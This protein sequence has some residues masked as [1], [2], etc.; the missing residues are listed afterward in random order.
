MPENT[1][2]AYQWALNNGASVL[3]TDVRL[4][5]D[6]TLFMFHDE[7]L[8]RITDGQGTVI[9]TADRQLRQL[10][11]ACRNHETQ[12]HAAP[13]PENVPLITLE[14]LFQ[15]L[16]DAAINIDIKDN[17]IE[18][19][20]EVNR[21]IERYDRRSLT[22]VGSFHASVILHLRALNP[23]IRTA[24]L[25]G[26]A[27]RLYFGR[28]LGLGTETSNYAALQIPT[29]YKGLPLATQSFVTYCQGL[30][31]EV[32]FWTVNEPEMFERLQ[33]LGV[34]G[35]VTDYSDIAQQVFT[36]RR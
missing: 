27:A 10:N 9:S 36:Q 26:E 8:E 29:R 33:A 17:L 23:M 6:G 4:S 31:L 22:T 2:S 13:V 7:S 19:A 30:G 16:P 5:R 18:A 21:L 14:E 3:E 1:L 28:W 15:R 25:K 24:A 35:V 32:V 34:N 20:D 12:F 11:A